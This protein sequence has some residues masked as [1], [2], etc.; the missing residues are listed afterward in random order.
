MTICTSCKKNVAVVFTT[1]IES[2]HRF[3]EGL[4]IKCAY[5]S[6]LGGLDGLLRN[7]GIN[8]NNIDEITERLNSFMSNSDFQSPESILKSL[9]KG[10]QDDISTET[11][12]FE[13]QDNGDNS[14]LIPVSSVSGSD[15]DDDS[16]SNGN[17][18]PGDGKELLRK[19]PISVKEN[20]RQLPKRKFLDQFGANLTLRASEGKVDRIIGRQKE[21]DRVIQ[22]LNR[23]SK[24]NPVLLG[25]PGVGKTAIAEGLA[26]RIS[27]GK[28]P[29]KLR[30]LEVYLLDLTAMVAGTQFRGQF[31]G[32]MKGVVD[33]AKRSGNIVLVIDE[34]H[35][36]MGAGDAEGAMNAGNI[37]KP[38]LAKGDIK[39]LGSTTLNEYRKFIEKDSALERRFQQVLVDEPDIEDSVSILM[40]V[41]DYYEEH[42]SVR[43]DEDVIRAAV[44]LSE[45][46]ITD[47]FLPDKAI[48][49]IDEAGS[50]ANLRDEKSIEIY[51]SAQRI[52][53]LES[54]LNSIG[55]VLSDKDDGEKLFEYQAELKSKICRE[56]DRYDKLVEAHTPVLITI[57]DIASVVEM[58]TGVPVQR[59]S[60]DE[61]DK[62]LKLEERL[63]Q[64]VIGQNQAVEA[65]ASAIRRKRAGFSAKHKPSSF[66]FVGP[67]GVGKTELVK[68]LAWAV[69][70]SEDN[71]IRLDMSEFME[72][73]TVSKM[74]GS[75][76]GYVGFDDGGQLTEKVRRK[77]YSVIL[78]DE[79]EKAHADVYNMLLQILD[80]GRL[81][82]SHGRMVNFEN[83]III[84]T[85]N[86]GTTLK[87]NS[88][89]FG[90]T[91]H[92]ALENRVDTVLKEIFRPE[93]LNR[94][95]EI[96]VFN[97]L[98]KDDLRRICDLMLKDVFATLAEKGIRLVVSDE[99]KDHITEKGYDS[100]FGARPLRKTIRKLLEDPLTDLLLKGSLDGAIGI[101]AT[102]SN[103]LIEFEI[104]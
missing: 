6:G 4:C 93:F 43:Y 45:R 63:R 31:E 16:E 97:E 60:E 44:I 89:G 87:G 90:S 92:T 37:L 34:L 38:A 70:G 81:T 104:L 28:V 99:V 22:I 74:I 14:S 72:S 77:P 15:P 66:I 98:S 30:G 101:S 65:L 73:H 23:R 36:I 11:N 58:W 88:I 52:D 3:N 83:T 10:F 102:L 40:G 91:G 51:E 100:K 12:S 49:L 56:K 84:M 9:I 50:R 5:E 42:H 21:L 54:S 103:D 78:F 47:R 55:T 2:G 59:I 13:E 96:V 32:R 95:D 94:V 39:V 17:I 80:D 61:S 20:N 26:V 76:P 29:V 86:A 8:E 41:K 35:N 82:D 71:M 48:D 69:F 64:R 85:S 75:P 7:A 19:K 33:D 57:E 27:E 1:R 53:S 67:T 24:N 79:I 25:E 18:V 46:Y 62:L 68:T